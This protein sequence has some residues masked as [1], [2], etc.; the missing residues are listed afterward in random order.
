MRFFDRYLKDEKNDWE[1]TPRIRWS[2][3]Q[4]GDAE[5]IQG[6][7]LPEF[8]LSNTEYRELFLAS[9]S[10]LS[11]SSPSGASSV[12]YASASSDGKVTFTYTFEKKSRLLGLPKAHLFMS[13]PDHHDW[14]VTVELQ[15]LDVDGTQM[16]H[17]TS[18]SRCSLVG[19]SSEA[20][21]HLIHGGSD[22]ARQS[23]SLD[24][25]SSP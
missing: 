11:P 25:T 15:K 4:F 2:V 24:A 21:Y 14:A 9:G 17:C 7:E 1:S 12:S 16:K 13:C 5:A 10:Q 6:I 20:D 8:P 3:L 23:P 19:V 22:C 18:K